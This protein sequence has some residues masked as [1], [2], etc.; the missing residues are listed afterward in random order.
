MLAAGAGTLDEL[1]LR[2]YDDVPV[3][4]HPMAKYSLWAHLLKLEREA[5]A[6]C[7]DERWSIAGR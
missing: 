3:A 4:M 2:A 7:R 6:Q 1:V 5:R